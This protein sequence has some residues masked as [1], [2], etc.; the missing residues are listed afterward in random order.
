MI[1]Q[2]AVI[3]VLVALFKRRGGVEQIA[4]MAEKGCGSK[5]RRNTYSLTGEKEVLTMKYPTG[6]YYTDADVGGRRQG[7]SLNSIG[8]FPADSPGTCKR[9]G[10]LARLWS[11]GAN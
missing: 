7:E 10:Y 5:G 3:S 1:A 9:D 2:M 8:R 11:N 4:E 6:F